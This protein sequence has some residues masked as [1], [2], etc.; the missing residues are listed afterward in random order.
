MVIYILSL[1]IIFK[2]IKEQFE[3]KKIKRFKLLILPIFFIFRLLYTFNFSSNQFEVLMFIII[4]SA[5]V[6][7]YQSTFTEIKLENLSM[8]NKNILTIYFKGGFNYLIGWIIIFISQIYISLIYTSEYLKIHNLSHELISEILKDLFILYRLFNQ[9]NSWYV[10][11]LYGFSTLSY[12]I[13]ISIK[14]KHI[15]KRLF[16]F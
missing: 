5:F 9:E 11:A 3:F 13:F 16:K 2:F 6:G 7:F 15:S 14:N 4:I 1:F 12:S 8:Q 10:W